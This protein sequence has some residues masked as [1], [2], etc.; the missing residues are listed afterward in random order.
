MSLRQASS[1]SARDALSIGVGVG[2]SILCLYLVTGYVVG[3]WSLRNFLA[4]LTPATAG[5]MVLASGMAIAVFAIPI[6]A[7]LRLQVA[8][9]LAILGV[10]LLG[11]IGLGFAQG[12]PL[13]A[14]YGLALYLSPVYL[15]LYLVCGGVEYRFRS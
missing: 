2:A 9:P 8:A 12:I 14:L 6:T 1:R 11:W 4:H 15:L 3:E 13:S 10:G 5:W 7:Y